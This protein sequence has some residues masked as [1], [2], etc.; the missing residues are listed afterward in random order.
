MKKII[1]SILLFAVTL[2]AFAACAD[3]NE[4][5]GTTAENFGTVLTTAQ[6]E[7][8]FGEFSIPSLNAWI[9]YPASDIDVSSEVPIDK[10]KI[11]FKYDES[12]IE[13]DTVAMKVTA[14]TKG[15]VKVEASSPDGSYKTTFYVKC[16][17][18]DKKSKDYDTSSYENYLKTLK[19][20]WT[21]NGHDGETSLFIGDSFFDERFY[22]TD[23]K[24]V[25][26]EID[27]LCCGISATTTCDWEK[28]AKSFLSSTDPKNIIMHI[29][30]NN[31][32]DDN[33]TEGETVSAL[34]RMFY[35]I[36][37]VC[38]YANIYWFNISQRNYDEGRQKI[39]AKVNEKMAK[40]CENRDWLTCV[41]TS[42]KLTNDMLRDGIH[43]KLQYYSVFMD[44][45]NKTDIVF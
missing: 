19:G 16:E 30:T 42:S 7:E 17:E 4:T 41:D 9:G 18:V 23:F 8:P 1:I 27:A 35:V 10:S 28:F 12:K 21:A 31:V 40:W 13:I 5:T 6:N 36:H 14:K 20:Y 25:N 15:S 43:P 3:K 39:V 34:Q 33:M 2:S 44:E 24:T 38:P 11:V 32:Y 45:L 29:G 22:W 37:D 26:K